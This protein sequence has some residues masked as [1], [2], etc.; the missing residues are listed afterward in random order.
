MEGILE[1]DSVIYNPNK[2]IIIA[3]VEVDP[4]NKVGFATHLGVYIFEG[5]LKS[6]KEKNPEYHFIH[7][8][9]E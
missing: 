2:K 5:S 9:F 8:T 6:F 1:K 4:S 3:V 7:E